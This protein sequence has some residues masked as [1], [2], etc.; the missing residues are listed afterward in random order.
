MTHEGT[1]ASR[2]RSISANER[3]TKRR[4]GNSRISSIEKIW[5]YATK[6]TGNWSTRVVDPFADGVGHSTLLLTAANRYHI[7]YSASSNGDLMHSDRC[8]M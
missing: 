1:T 6:S 4:S 7:I 2:L 3:E 8:A 5:R